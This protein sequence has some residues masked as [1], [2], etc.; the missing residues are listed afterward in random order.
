VPGRR[1]GRTSPLER[2]GAGISRRRWAVLAAGGLALLASFAYGPGVFG[3]LA[4]SGF[5]DPAS[6]SARAER[7]ATQQF[8]HDSDLLLVYSSRSGT[9]DDPAY[10][11]KVEKDIASLPEGAVAEVET[12]WTSRAPALVSQDRR[13]T[14]AALRLAGDDDDS[15][16]QTFTR[17]R[18]QLESPPAT[19]R[20]GITG[21][22]AVDADL[23][24]QAE[25]D[26]R[27]AEMLALPALLLLL[28]LIFR[29][30]VAAA[31]PLV[32]GMLSI[33]GSFAVLRGIS[34]VTDVSVFSINVVTML[35]LGLAVDY[36]LFI[37]SRYRE[38]LR[39]GADRVKALSTT[40]E[41]AGRTVAMSG[42]IVAT[43]LAS[44]LLFPQVYLRSMGLGGLA[45]VLIALAA[46]LTVLPALLVTLGHRV[47]AGR[48][49]RRRRTGSHA[50]APLGAWYRV[51]RSVMRRPSAYLG[52]VAVLLVMLGAPF[53]RV[54]FGGVDYRALPDGTPSREALESIVTDFPASTE[55]IDA[56]VTFNSPIATPGSTE[57]LRR[58]V[59]H[60]A[61]LPNVTHAE[62]TRSAG[63][64]ALIRIDHR[65][66][67]LRSPARDLVAAVRAEPAPAGAQVLVGGSSAETAD[68][69]TSLR[70][71][72]PWMLVVIVAVTFI[73]LF[74]AFG[75]VVIPLKAILTTLLSLAA[76]FGALVWIFQDG[77][78][79]GPLGFTSTGTVEATQPVL[80]FA[81]AFG[82][83]TDY[84]V[85]LLSRIREHWVRTGDNSAAVTTALQRTGPIITGAALLLVVVIGAFSTS[86]ITL[87]K[88][89][90]V[91]MLVT[92]LLDA[93]IVRGLLVPATM[94]LLGPVNWWAPAPMHRFWL[95]HGLHEPA[96]E[97]R[98]GGPVAEPGSAGQSTA[99]ASRNP[100][101]P[102]RHARVDSFAIAPGQELSP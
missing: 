69:L 64:T 39:V 8:G 41:T 68:L 62:V 50:A 59:G 70:A 14:V 16:E 51:A 28:V 97:P 52:A 63:N 38:E 20:V 49:S 17:I 15:R 79:S 100:S 37:V 74:M 67:P 25:S 98:T 76:S 42:L 5:A 56:V 53:L 71:T 7:V 34:L 75:S 83:A 43:S 96:Y 13:S 65:L 82:L 48:P 78:L 73:V 66:D 87:V 24:H 22:L 2:L 94:A 44:L 1:A 54:E 99:P 19:L 36:S 27:R 61:A 18:P 31:L 45:A 26:L 29:G 81:V 85:F 90:G 30:P 89:V 101:G 102:A 4:D 40:M 86:G 23:N 32:I 3:S 10:R 47:D 21:D 93:T 60:V 84:E 77:N 35:G 33:L 55:P 6:E 12:F 72:L 57:A 91:G 92:V 95:R 58:Y 88:M 80:M 11:H 46:S 9:V